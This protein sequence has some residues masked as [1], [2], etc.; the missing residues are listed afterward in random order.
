MLV[1]IVFTITITTEHLPTWRRRPVWRWEYG[2]PVPPLATMTATAGSIS[3]FPA[4]RAMI[5]TIRLRWV[6]SQSCRTPA[7]IRGVSVFCGPRGLKGE[8]DH[9]F[10]NNGDGTFT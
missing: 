9:L 4:T 7:N 3:S 2:P 6:Q 1:R 8:H 5:S 10:H